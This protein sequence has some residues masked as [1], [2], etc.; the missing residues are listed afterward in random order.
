MVR[1]RAEGSLIGA[2]FASLER[3]RTYIRL[4]SNDRWLTVP[5]FLSLSRIALIPVWW[6]LMREGHTTSGAILIM[7]AFASDVVDGWIARRWDQASKWGRVLDPL[8][9]KLA[10]LVVGLFCVMYRD[11]PVSAYALTIARDLSLLIGGWVIMRRTLT[12]PASVDFGRYAALLWAIVLL[13][14]AFDWQP[15][16]SYTVWPAVIIYLLAGLYYVR[17]VVSPAAR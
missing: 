3:T 4:V 5:N 15:Y 11:M 7:Y 2:I 17:R 6:W 16:A 10:A 13:L 14:Y 9:D 12:P 1:G 8:G